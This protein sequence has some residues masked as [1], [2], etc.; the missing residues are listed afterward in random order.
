MLSINRVFTEK[1]N[2]GSPMT[3][4]QALSI[5]VD[6][7]C[8]VSGLLQVPSA[9]RACYVLA[10]GAGA[11]MSHPLWQPSQMASPNA[12]L[13]HCAINSLTWKRLAS[14]RMYKD[15]SGHRPR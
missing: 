2:G 15:C 12:T 14:D 1:S 6:E 8:R 11:G 5:A 9:A 13:P 3:Q 7:K 10:H 4:P